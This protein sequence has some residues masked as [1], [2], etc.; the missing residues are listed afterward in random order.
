MGLAFLV[1][2]FLAGLA[3]LVI[4]L[5]IHLRQREWERPRRFPSLMFLRRIPIRT[6]RRR[7]VTDWL[8]LLLR[9]G[10]F[11]LLVAAFA[12]PFLHQNV[13]TP[14]SAPAR[15]VVLLLDRSMS[16][17]HREVWPAALDS[18]RRIV[19]ELRPQDRAALVLFDEEAE[20]VQPLTADHGA[21]LAALATA[22]PSA[23]ATRYAAALRAGRQVLTTALGRPGEILV[24]TDLQ[25]SGLSGLAG[26]ELPAGVA[27]RAVPVTPS[28]RANTAIV[29]ADVQ[30]VASGDRSTLLVAARL[31]SH[32]LHG[33][34]RALLSLSV[35]G[36]PAASRE[37]T[38][39]ADGAVTAAF[40]PVPLAAGRARAEL[41]LTPDA[42]TADDSLRLVVPAEQALRVLLIAPE[43]ARAD[44]TLFLER[45]LAIGREP[46]IA[47]ERHATLDARALRGAAVVLFFD[48]PVPSGAVGAA[49][50]QWTRDGGGVLV[51]AGARLAARSTTNPLMPGV[52]RGSIE[53][54]ADRGGSFGEVS[55]DH[56]IFAPFREGGGAAL[57][58]ARFLRYP[59]VE[60]GVGAEVLARF[61]DGTPA[62]LERGHGNGRL[63][64][65][66]APLDG[67]TG[68]FPL[69]PAY[70]PFLRRLVMHAAGHQVAPLWR[71]TGE[72]GS[73]PSGMKDPVVALPGGGLLRPASD[74]GPCTLVLTEAGFY[75]VYAGRAAGEP[76]EILAANPAAAESDLTPA[77]PREL[78]L[79]VRR[80]D[81]TAAAALA[82]PAPA[83][84]EGQQRLWRALLVLA[85]V[86]L[87]TET[88][89]ANRGWRGTAAQVLP[90]PP[91]RKSHE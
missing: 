36:R 27:V 82:P 30:R 1:P 60:P 80:G 59:R 48:A 6:A 33:S 62:L 77:D 63:L 2:A 21:V 87:M 22:R 39:P 55:L 45:A 58:A 57:G 91:E 90:A 81:S 13:V 67:L 4:P 49:L 14:T 42:L 84:R 31:M 88:I 7:R 41:S 34:R 29:G 66:A 37:V 86:L 24:V 61:D 18:V 89:V 5:I 47:L 73:V 69:Q 20:V 65:L 46:R 51:A 83:E 74:S 56:P 25:R 26:L 3:A 23:R 68:D 17:S 78:L 50:D 32:E 85:A 52:L 70:L 11:A 9:A 15:A 12:R 40:D 28:S 75:Q 71:T 10:V 35:N 79:G 8:L 38:L 54:L 53:R 76:V 44:E 72:T 19:A 64:L 16:M 43:G